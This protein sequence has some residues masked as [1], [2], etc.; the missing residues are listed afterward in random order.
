MSRQDNL[1][2][3]TVFIKYHINTMV[4][5]IKIRLYKLSKVVLS[6]TFLLCYCNMLKKVPT[7]K[8]GVHLSEL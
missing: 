3:M 7:T 8:R 2:Q 1:G 4:Y 5:I 6:T